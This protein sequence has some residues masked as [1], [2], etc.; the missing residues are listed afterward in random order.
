[1]AHIGYRGLVVRTR[2]AP[3]VKRDI[4]ETIEVVRHD[5]RA[6]Q[7]HCPAHDD[8]RASLS[9]GRGDG[10]RV[11]LHCHAGCKTDEVLMAA[12]LTMADLQERRDGVTTQI[13]ATYD[14]CD[15]QGTL[16]YQICRLSPKGFRQ[17][18]PDGADSWIWNVE[19][20]RRVLFGL[21]ELSGRT[22]AY[23]VEGEKDVLALRNIGL[24]ATTNAG[25]AG[26][27]REEYTNQLRAAGVTCV[28]ILPDHDGPGL[29]HAAV[30]G[31]SC[32]S[33]GLRVK[34]L[35]LPGLSDKGDVSDWLAA[36]HTRDEL[37]TLAN[38]TVPWQPR[39]EAVLTAKSER[40]RIEGRPVIVCLRDVRPEPVKWLWP[41]RLAAGKLALLVGDPGLGKSWI[42]LDMA[43]RLS[44][45]RAW[46]DEA[47]AALGP[48]G[49]ILLSAE[50]GLAD[51]IRPRLDALGADSSRIHHIAVLQAGEQERGIQL[52][53]TVALEHAI[54]Q[55][56]SQIVVIDPMAAYLGA[57]D[58]HRDADVRGLIAPL[59]ALADRT[60][61]AI[62]GIMHLSKGTQRPAIYRAVG[63]IAFAA[64][65]RIVL[66][67]AKDPER[68][69]R[70]IMAVVKSNL[71]APPPAL[72]Y[73]LADDRLSWETSPVSD[74]DVDVLLS[75]PQTP[76]AREEQTEADQMIGELLEDRAAWPMEAR[77]ALAA[78][79]ARGIHPRALQRAA[80]RRRIRI[81]R[82]G[83]G[84]GGRWIWDPPI[85]DTIDDKNTG[86]SSMSS[87]SSMEPDRGEL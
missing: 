85:D 20:V 51:T 60:N 52:A 4:R 76:F 46:P 10:G 54:T 82:R 67:V 36:G 30:V 69:T 57:T 15:E 65:A 50:D 39:T 75:T 6:R 13:I 79:S 78:G 1:M 3:P 14:Y 87:M 77:D 40:D 38:A 55:T 34:I 68:D 59:A 31:R 71:A 32:R 27:W 73:T 72:A 56:A 5:G 80:H 64:A 33:A 84:R 18:R 29:N 35:A 16:L 53:D 41:G 81:H 37:V 61:V 7:V 26:K 11:L 83:F 21:S 43:A 9:I 19:G 22:I 49:V 58:S 63:S 86:T 48:A 8:R 23:I 62:L 17:R 24:V 12:G 2:G 66:A 74:L 45:S 28:V 44:A 25:G 47:P 70:R 42:A